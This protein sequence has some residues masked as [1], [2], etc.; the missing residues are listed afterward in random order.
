MVRGE[1]LAGRG[2]RHARGGRGGCRASRSSSWRHRSARSS[3]RSHTV[4]ERALGIYERLGDRTGVMS[5]VIAMAYARYGPV[6][7]L[8]SSARHLEE[9]RR[10]TS[11]LSELVTESERDRLDLQMLFGVHVYSRAKVVPDLALSR[12]EDAYR[13]AR[14]QGD[15]AIEFLAAGGVAMTL[16][17]LG[18]VEGAERWLEHGGRGGFHGP[19]ARPLDPARDVARHRPGAAPGD[20]AGMRGHLEK[21]V[22]MATE[23]GQASARCEALARL[24]V[25]AARLVAREA[26]S[27]TPDPALVELVERSAAQVKEVLPLLPGHAPWGAQADAALATVALARGDPAG[28]AIAGGAAFA[29]APGGAPRGH[30]PGDHRPGGARR[31]SPARRRRSRAPSGTTSG[32]PCRASPRAPPTNSIRVRWLTG[33]IGRE[34]VELAGP[35]DAPDRCRRQ[36][37]PAGRRPGRDGAPTA[38]APDRG[39]DERRDRGRA[40]PGRGRTSSSAWR[41]CSPSSAPRAAP[42]RP[43]SRSA[44]WRPW[45]PA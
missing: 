45:G 5:T 8:S 40:R 30:Q 35:L 20:A 29:G 22:A 2:E 9:I 4:L 13:A 23:G 42:R 26:Q 43:R 18:D 1:V 36:P 17:D 21:A 33:P 3:S 7:H 37:G 15:R 38:P 6:M 11:R 39:S 27:G 16:L 28:A 34:L 19:V 41:A 32:R 25:E 31:S 10:V 12:G 24:A 44:G 14:L